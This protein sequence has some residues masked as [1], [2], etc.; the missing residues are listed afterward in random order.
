ME[1]L[2]NK[3]SKERAE[4]PRYVKIDYHGHFYVSKPLLRM[5]GEPRKGR[6]FVAL[7]D[8]NIYLIPDDEGNIK[9]NQ[10]GFNTLYIAQKIYKLYDIPC[11]VSHEIKL[12]YQETIEHPEHGTCYLLT[13]VCTCEEGEIHNNLT[14]PAQTGLQWNKKT[15]SRIKRT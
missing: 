11:D 13:P 1:I 7:E 5:I 3:S 9:L 8:K 6:L 2:E 4:G 14:C 12:N 10:Q 15:R